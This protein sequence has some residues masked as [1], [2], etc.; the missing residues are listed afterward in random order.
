MDVVG[1]KGVPLLPHIRLQ[2]AELGPQIPL[3]IRLPHQLMIG[4]QD[5][6][7][8]RRIPAHVLLTHKR[9]QIGALTQPVLNPLR[10][11]E[12]LPDRLE[13]GRGQ[14][15]ARL[16]HLGLRQLRHILEL[17]LDLQLGPIPVT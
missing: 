14:V 7:T 6:Q 12:D 8:E 3:P 5:G 17:R 11:R 13:G 16:G 15:S 1:R 4:L 2:S 10:R 9:Y